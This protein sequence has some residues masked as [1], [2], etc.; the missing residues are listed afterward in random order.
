MFHASRFLFVLAAFV[1]EIQAIALNVTPSTIPVG[2]VFVVQWF[3]DAGDPTQFPLWIVNASGGLGTPL[4]LV[5][6]N[7]GSGYSLS[8]KQ[9]HT[10]LIP[11]PFHV[12]AY[13]D[14]NATYEF[15]SSNEA[16]V[17]DPNASTTTSSKPPN[18]SNTSNTQSSTTSSQSTNP[19]LPAQNNDTSSTSSSN[20]PLIAGI[21][22]VGA[23]AAIALIALLFICLRKRQK[24]YATDSR[25]L[26]AEP[27]SPGIAS[28]NVS[29]NGG[30][31][32]VPAGPNAPEMSQAAG[33]SP[34]API[35]SPGFALANRSEGQDHSRLNSL[36]A[37]TRS[38]GTF[39]GSR[40]AASTEASAGASQRSHPRDVK[41]H[42]PM[43]SG[44]SE[45]PPEYLQNVA[46]S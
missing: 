40:S 7:N 3:R 20:T 37:E 25:R 41:T 31:P 32:N 14:D 21:A 44:N 39:F 19:S 12:V 22:V 8:G 6:S 42:T 23:V 36:D 28:S 18:Q 24:P 16:T 9:T 2:N 38:V 27:F 17:V 1:V 26:I 46:A 30:H 11:G 29:M 15:A 13:N 35:R 10:A 43:L 45:P 34:F 33:T 4:S 5:L